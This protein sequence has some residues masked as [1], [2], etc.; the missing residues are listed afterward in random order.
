[1]NVVDTLYQILTGV[2]PPDETSNAASKIDSVVIMQALIHRPREQVYETLNVIC[3]LLPRP[4]IM[5]DLDYEIFER[6]DDSM[7]DLEGPPTQRKSRSA[8]RL[9][10]LDGCKDQTRRFALILLPTL[11]DAYSSTVNLSVRQK[12]LT[13]QLKV[14]SNLDTSVVEEALRPVPY[15]SFLA[16]ILSQEDHPSLVM[17]ALQAS[18]LLFDRLEDI[19]QYQFHREGVI[20]EISKIAERTSQLDSKIL[21]KNIKKMQPAG[22]NLTSRV[23]GAGKRC[24]ERC[25]TGR[26]G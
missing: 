13:A 25:R 24:R 11:T 23:V 20:G 6:F 17:F 16:S 14:L 9:E 21:A 4:K 3:E 18:E 7:S 1:M 26:P 22:E 12:V 10:L 8:R 15:A 5:L 2:S 19:Y